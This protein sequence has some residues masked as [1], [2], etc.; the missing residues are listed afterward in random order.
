[1]H[2]KH[3]QHRNIQIYFCN[4]R[5]KHLQ[6]CSKTFETRETFACNMRQTLAKTGDG[7]LGRWWTSTWATRPTR[8]R[9]RW[10]PWSPSWSFAVCSRTARCA[11]RLR[12]SRCLGASRATAEQ[13]RG[14]AASAGRRRCEGL[15]AGR[16]RPQA[17]AAIVNG[18]GTGREWD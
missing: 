18:G 14:L 1:M 17:P 5:I 7:E 10:W 4:I 9:R 3:V 13:A 11:R 6:H 15:V 16:R 12:S 8:R 2:L